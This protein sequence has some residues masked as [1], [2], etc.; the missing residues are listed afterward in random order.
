M[1][2]KILPLIAGV[3]ALSGC[4]EYTEGFG[5]GAR[6]GV[7]RLAEYLCG[8]AGPLDT[9]ADGL[10]QAAEWG[11]YSRLAYSAWDEDVNG[12]VTRAEFDD[13][14]SE[15]GFPAA[16]PTPSDAAWAAFNPD[17]DDYLNSYE[18]WSESVWTRLDTNRNGVADAGEWTW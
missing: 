15:G 3:I 14:W 11:R 10:V 12:R 18:F 7:Y 17:G 5:L 9:N 2:S 1:K 6:D 8:A 16:E 4:S 13:C